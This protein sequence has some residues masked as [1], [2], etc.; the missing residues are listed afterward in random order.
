VNSSDDAMISMT[1]QGI[2]QSWNSGA[3]FFGYAAHETP[4]LPRPRPSPVSLIATICCRGASSYW[5]DSGND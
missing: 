5:R 1:L 2:I 4:E 3:E